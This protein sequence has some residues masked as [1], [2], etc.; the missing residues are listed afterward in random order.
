MQFVLEPP[1]QM[2]VVKVEMQSRAIVIT[3]VM[4]KGQHVVKSAY[5]TA[6]G[7]GGTESKAVVLF[8]A[9]TGEFT[10]QRIDGDPVRFDFDLPKAEFAQKRQAIR[11]AG[12]L[13]GKAR[14]SKK[15]EGE[16][17]TAD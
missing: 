9:N 5:L 13:G 3:P 17:A 10:I 11:R 8:N 15:E 16:D 6:K 2:E 12:Q 14:A 4:L 7:V 1:Q